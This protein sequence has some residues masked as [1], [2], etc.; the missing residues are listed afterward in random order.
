MTKN[1]RKVLNQE[2]MRFGHRWT[3]EEIISLMQL[4][5]KGTPVDDIAE[6]L[7]TTDHAIGHMVTRLRKQGIPLKRRTRGRKLGGTQR[8]GQLWTQAEIDYLVTRRRDRATQ[9][10]IATELGRSWVAVAGM[11][12]RLRRLGLAVPR[13]GIGMRRLYDVAALRTTYGTEPAFDK[14]AAS[15]NSLE[16]YKVQ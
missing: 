4:W 11:I 5:D 1:E 9:E 7:G 15:E 16:H 2:R 12:Q 13:F 3:H 10:E 14:E 6:A 8:F